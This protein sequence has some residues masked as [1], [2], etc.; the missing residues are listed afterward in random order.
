MILI[1]FLAQAEGEVAALNRRIQLLE[2]VNIDQL[3]LSKRILKGTKHKE[4]NQKYTSTP[5]RTLRGA[6]RGSQLPPRS[7]QRP[8]TLL[9]SQSGEIS[10]SFNIFIMIYR[11]KSF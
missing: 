5:R 11:I 9:M 8:A 7:S 6:R 3:N 10:F 4:H 2:E 1:L